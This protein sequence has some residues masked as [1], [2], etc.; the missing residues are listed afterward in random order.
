MPSTPPRTFMPRKTPVWS[1]ATVRFQSA[2]LVSSIARQIAEAG[3]VDEDVE[4]AALGEHALDGGLPAGLVGHV[5]V[6]VERFAARVADRR[7]RLL[8]RL[9]LH[10]CDRD[11]GALGRAP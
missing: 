2:R 5:E 3:V 11:R 8:A 9:V 6:H 1:I 7:G 4:P 10:V